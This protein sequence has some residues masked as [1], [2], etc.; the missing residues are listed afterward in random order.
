MGSKSNSFIVTLTPDGR[1]TL[2]PTALTDLQ[3]TPGM[4][5]MV[6][7]EADGL[8]LRLAPLEGER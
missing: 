8:T 3:W 7:Q 1:I 2:P 5:L 4:Q 6:M